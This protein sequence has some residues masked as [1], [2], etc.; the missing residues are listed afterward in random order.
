ME[1][2]RILQKLEKFRD[3]IL[4]HM[5]QLAKTLPEYY[6][7]LDMGGVGETLAPKL[8]AVI[9]DV[10]RFHSRNA[11]TAYAGIDAPPYQSESFTA[12]ER[13]ISRRGNKYL[14][15]TGYEVMQSLIQHKPDEDVV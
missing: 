3:T 2:V 9:G 7:V 6:I 11:L 8:I 10:C 15:K 1:N 12:N 13:H 4:T 14:R 5:K